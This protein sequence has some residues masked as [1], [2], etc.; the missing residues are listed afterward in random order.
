MSGVLKRTSTLEDQSSQNTN[1]IKELQ[2]EI[3]GLKGTVAAQEKTIADLKL[4]KEDIAHL[5]TDF[6]QESSEQ[7]Q[8][9]NRLIGVQQKQVDG[10]HDTNN[11]I[12]DVIQENLKQYFQEEMDNWTKDNDYKSLKDQAQHNKINLVLI[13]LQEEDK[14][15]L[16]SASDFISSTLGIKGVK[17]FS[18]HRL[19][20]APPEG[21]SYARPIL[22]K[23]ANMAD[24]YKVW[25]RRTL[26][27]SE[28]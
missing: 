18:A 12:Q 1:A 27:T 14:A 9:F 4:L 8:E 26:I 13:G 24:R 16:V 21:S 23:F 25:K 11:K 20:S 15:P 22:M 7:V 17:I 6:T 5:K 28:D 19:G 2:E 10:F 3:K